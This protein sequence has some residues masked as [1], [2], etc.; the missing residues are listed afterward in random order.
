MA[1]HST[2]PATAQAPPAD[3]RSGLQTIRDLLPSLWPRGDIG[4]HVRVIISSIFLVAAKG[5]NV[6]VPLAYAAAVD[7]LTPTNLPG[8]TALIVIPAALIL[9]YGLLRVSASF[10]GSLKRPVELA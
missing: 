10:F 1:A 3:T 2:T 5:A 6:V 7:A 4:S 9:G 8:R